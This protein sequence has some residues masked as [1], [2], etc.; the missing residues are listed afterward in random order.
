MITL[1]KELIMKKL[2]ATFAL[3]LLTCLTLF[4][5]PALANADIYKGGSWVGYVNGSNIYKG[6]SWV[7]YVNGSDIY[8]GGSWAGYVNGSDIYKGGS[9][10]GY[11]KGDMDNVAEGAALLLVFE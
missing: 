10:A 2:F 1:P 8:K 4:Q 7:G 11:A 9:W 6:G 5:A 3:V